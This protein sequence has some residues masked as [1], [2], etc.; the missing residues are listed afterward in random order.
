MKKPRNPYALAAKLAR[1]AIV[2]NRKK[3]TRK[4][5]HKGTPTC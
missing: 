2:R 3:Y 1:A 5:K 4:N